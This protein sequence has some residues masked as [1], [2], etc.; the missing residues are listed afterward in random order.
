MTSALTAPRALSS[1]PG[2]LQVTLPGAHQGVLF[3]GD[4]EVLKPLKMIFDKAAGLL[5]QV[6]A[7]ADP[8]RGCPRVAFSKEGMAP[9][10]AA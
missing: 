7:L 10:C 6:L 3:H 8:R 1:I 2:L 9:L 4:T 5:T